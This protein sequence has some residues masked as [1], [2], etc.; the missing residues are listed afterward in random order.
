MYTLEVTEP[1]YWNS[2][3]FIDHAGAS[4]KSKDKI[5]NMNNSAL[6]SRLSDII[7]S[8]SSKSILVVALPFKIVLFLSS[9]HFQDLKSLEKLSQIIYL[10]NEYILPLPLN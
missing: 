2:A 1:L 7:G 6:C 3:G 10:Y 8:S 5:G 9:L 4:A